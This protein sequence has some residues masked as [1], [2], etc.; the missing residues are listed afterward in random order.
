LQRVVIREVGITFESEEDAYEMYN[1]YAGKVG[2]SVRRSN[3]KRRADKTI[4]SKLLVCSKR[5]FGTTRTG[6]NA[7]IQFGVSREGVWTVQ[8]IVPEHN[9]YLASPNKACKLR[10]QRRVIEADRLLIAQIREAGMKPSQV[11][12]FMKQIYG[13][14]EN[15]PFSR[16]DCNNEIGQE[17]KKYL[18]SNDAQTLLEYLKNKQ[19]EDHAFFMLFK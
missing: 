11:Y 13:G 17:R 15:I 3:T 12:E 1:I 7:S 5:G 19:I 2:F 9:H 8:K 10:S 16:T 14:G 4:Y 6:C 18:E